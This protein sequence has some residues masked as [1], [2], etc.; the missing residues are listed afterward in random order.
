[1]KYLSYIV[2]LVMVLTV[3][4]SGQKAPTEAGPDDEVVITDSITTKI[5]TDGGDVGVVIDVRAIFKKGYEAT[6]AEIT[7]P[8]HQE[9]SATLD[10]DP[11]TNLAILSIVADS[12]TEVE[13]TAFAAGVNANI[14]ISDAAGMTLADFHDAALVIDNSN[15]PLS[16][17]TDMPY[18]R[19]PMALRQDLPYLLQLEGRDG[20]M[21]ATFNTLNVSPDTAFV[22]DEVAQQ[23]YFRPVQG[24]ADTYYVENFRHPVFTVWRLREENTLIFSDDSTRWA[25]ADLVLEQDEDGWVKMRLKDTQEYLVFADL[26]NLGGVMTYISTND[27]SRFRLISDIAWQVEDRGTV[28]NQPNMSP[29]TLDF[30]YKATL[31][32]CSAATLTESIGRSEQRTTTTTVGTSESLQLFASVSLSASVTFGLSVTGKIG[33]KI[34]P[35]EAS[36]AATQSVE[37]SAGIEVT[38]SL[39]IT[40]EST[41]SE[42]TSITTEVSR[43]RTLTLPPFTAL[44]A[45]DAV[46][47][48]RNVRVPF[49]QVLRITATSKDDG[50][51]LSGREI[52]TLMLFNFVGGVVSRVGADFIDI[53]FRGHATIDQMF[54]STTNVQEIPGACD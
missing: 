16:I 38:T 14:V 37:I 3:G 48:I 34:M 52:Q 9:F 39:T 2:T 28:F 6:T 13:L 54:E 1:M 32:N 18:V 50:S 53:G 40:S 33:F 47:T 25:R 45:W 49:T 5:H 43:I 42:T 21:S 51:A 26:E 15:L 35:I 23:F 41:W 19:R 24:S 29:A 4:C 22:I 31:I 12:L 46:K 7:F 11:S 30:A 17:S 27:P 10:I 36:G 20:L 44:E 8:D